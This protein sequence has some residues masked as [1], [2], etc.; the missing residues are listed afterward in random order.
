MIP[1]NNQLLESHIRSVLNNHF[2]GQYK[3]NATSFNF[4]CNICGDSKS[5]PKK[6]RGYILTSKQNW[7]YYCQRCNASLLAVN[8]LKEYFPSNYKDYIRDLMSGVKQIQSSTE[9]PQVKNTYSEKFDV[10]FF[11]PIL[12]G[13]GKLFDDALNF[14]SKR[15]IPEE[16]YSKWFVSLGGTYK[17]RVIIPYYSSSNK[18]YNWQGRS[19]VPVHNKYI[20]R[21]GEHCNIYN[22]DFVDKNK[23]VVVFEGPI[24]SMSTVNAIGISGAGKAFSD[25][26]NIFPSKRFIM[27]N[28]EKGRETALKLLERGEYVFLWD[29]F[30]KKYNL[31]S[32]QKKIDFNDCMIYLNRTEKF[33]FEEL[34]EFFTNSIYSKIEFL[35]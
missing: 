34:E 28:D 18:I 2:N 26:L 11:T 31:P 19:L 21:I 30:I 33:T 6:R 4:R 10:N 8:W 17:N 24:D 20:F 32:D 7:V 5:N 16:I 29:R 15:M 12:K 27:D 14:C 25:N 9:Q 22:R 13:K 3:R 23:E 35:K 1:Q